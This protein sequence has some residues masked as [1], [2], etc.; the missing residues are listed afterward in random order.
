M[1]NQEFLAQWD[2]GEHVIT[3]QM[4]GLSYGYDLGIQTIAMEMLCGIIA[5]PPEWGGHEGDPKYW[6]E[7]RDSIEEK[8][9]VKTAIAKVQPSG[10]MFGAA[11]NLAINMA[12]RGYEASLASVPPDRHMTMRRDHAP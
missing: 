10:A 3:I 1:D 2:A 8:A 11:W 4:G 6:T 5:S 7:Y 12:K 9:Y